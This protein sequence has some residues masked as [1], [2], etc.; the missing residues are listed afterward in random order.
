M[1]STSSPFLLTT[2]RRASSRRFPIL[3]TLTLLYLQKFAARCAGANAVQSGLYEAELLQPRLNFIGQHACTSVVDLPQPVPLVAAQILSADI[4][5]HRDDPQLQ[6]PRVPDAGVVVKFNPFEG[7]G[8]GSTA[9][10][11]PN[12]DFSQDAAE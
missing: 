10:A 9:Q 2:D 8:G 3:S 1:L 12:I 5:C 7:T 6:L 4:F 11:I